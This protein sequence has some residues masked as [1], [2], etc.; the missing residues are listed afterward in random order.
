MPDALVLPD[1][2]AHRAP[3]VAPDRTANR[4]PVAQTGPPD[5]ADKAASAPPGR[6]ATILFEVPFASAMSDLDIALLARTLDLTVQMT[7]KLR[8]SP[9]GPAAVRLD[10]DSG[11]FLERGAADGQWV[12]EGR[13]W[14][15]PV[16]QSIHEWH[17]LAAGAARLLDPAVP[18]LERL[19]P[20]GDEEPVHP[21]GSA[22]N[23]RHARLGRRILRLS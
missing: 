7:P 1:E 10:H 8:P 2:A 15:D 14:G 9:S 5:P 22:A 17:V 21:V 20:V 6:G 12:L 13:S 16:A 11:L 4:Q 23:G 18:F 19:T 3:P